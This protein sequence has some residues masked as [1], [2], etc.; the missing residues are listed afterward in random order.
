MP[1]SCE[2]QRLAQLTSGELSFDQAVPHFSYKDE[3][4]YLDDMLGAD[5]FNPIGTQVE[6]GSIIQ[7]TGIA[8]HLP[9]SDPPPIENPTV[10]VWEKNLLPSQAP[11]KYEI[12][13]RIGPSNG[14]FINNRTGNYEATAQKFQE[15][16][17]KFKGFI[18]VQVDPIPPQG[19][20]TN[21]FVSPSL[22]ILSTDMAWGAIGGSGLSVYPGGAGLIYLLDVYC[23]NALAD[24][25]SYRLGILGGV[26]LAGSLYIYTEVH[27][28]IMPLST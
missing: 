23:G 7:L 2:P 10:V 20:E 28:P 16:R 22:G 3:K 13:V 4:L 27:E 8:H 11:Y 9:P 24:Q 21:V 6:V 14:F 1:L 18:E 17:C 26:N 19:I 12:V 15:S 5:F 25:I